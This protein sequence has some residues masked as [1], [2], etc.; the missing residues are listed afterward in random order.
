M[1]T[2]PVRASA[3]W[4]T[5]REPAD[6]AARSVELVEALRPHLPDGRDLVVHD[7]GSGSGSMARW[8]APRL[9]GRQHWILYDRDVELLEMVPANPPA[10]PAGAGPLTCD[11]VAVTVAGG[12]GSPSSVTEPCIVACA[13]SVTC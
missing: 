6:A 1:F 7:L 8:L 11:Q 2:E 5:L 4:L 12:F 10:V 3:R 9:P 13:G